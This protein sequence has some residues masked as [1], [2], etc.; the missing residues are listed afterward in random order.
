MEALIQPI[1]SPLQL[2]RYF[3]K[4]LHFELY[5]GFDRTKV[6]LEGMAIPNVEIGVVSIDQNPDN[7][8]QWRFEVKL[9][10]L[11]PQDTPFPYKVETTVVGYFTV[12]GHY[13][14]E[15]AER[16]AKTNGPALLYSSAREIVASV[17]GRSSYSPLLIPS[18]TFIQPEEE[19][20]PEVKQLPPANEQQ[21][22]ENKG[23]VKKTPKKRK[24]KGTDTQE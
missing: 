18:V 21:T 13:P 4:R 9:E 7:P 19:A 16:L 11:D 15:R 10:L 14:A 20:M 2:D 17:T 22:I 24:K 12:S 23:G 1:T 6:P 3:L 8:L 5:E